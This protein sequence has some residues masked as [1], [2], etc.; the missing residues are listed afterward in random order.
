VAE[1]GFARY[2]RDQQKFPLLT[3]EEEQVLAR[4]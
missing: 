1:P 2:L 3:Q 4:R